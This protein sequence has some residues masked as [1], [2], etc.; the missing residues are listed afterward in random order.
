M[1]LAHAI[2]KPVVAGALICSFLIVSSSCG[3]NTGSATERGYKGSDTEHMQEE[4]EQSGE[5]VDQKA[6]HGGDH[7]ETTTN[8]GHAEG[9]A[10]QTGHAADST[11]NKTNQVDTEAEL[12]KEEH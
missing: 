9:T 11:Q 5:H 10:S 8:R 1:K 6:K 7:A 3:S 4:I 12:H 2:W